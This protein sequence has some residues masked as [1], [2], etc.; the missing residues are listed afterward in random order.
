S[1]TELLT[2][3]PVKIALYRALIAARRFLYGVR[4]SASVDSCLPVC[5][6]HLTIVWS[7]V[8]IAAHLA[9]NR[10]ALSFYRST[11]TAP[12]HISSHVR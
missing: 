8:V 10:I 2:K 12:Q 5:V 1:S 6:L 7:H 9:D 11:P 3:P 4:P